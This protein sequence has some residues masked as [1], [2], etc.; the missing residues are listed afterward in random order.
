MEMTARFSTTTS[1]VLRTVKMKEYASLREHHLI[2]AVPVPLPDQHVKR[3]LQLL[4]LVLMA[5]LDLPA[6]RLVYPRT[7]AAVTLPV[8]PLTIKFAMLAGLEQT[9]TRK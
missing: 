2:A 8:M 6:L 5:H 7:H 1:H 9:V 3:S 4:L